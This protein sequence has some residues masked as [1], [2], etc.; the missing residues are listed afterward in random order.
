V[1]TFVRFVKRQIIS[2]INGDLSTISRKL[3]KL[4]PHLMYFPLYVLAI[5]VVIII[6]IIGPI[7]LI[8]WNGALASRIGTFAANLELYLCEKDSGINVPKQRYFDIFFPEYIPICNNQLLL[9]WKRVL[10]IWPR[11]IFYPI[12][13]VNKIIP[14]GDAHEFST[15]CNDR[16]FYNL[17]DQSLPHLFFTEDEEE[18][19]AQGLLNLGIPIENKFVCLMVRDSAYLPELNYHSYRDGDINKYILAA[20]ELTRRGYYVIRMGAAVNQKLESKNPKIID[21]ATNGYRSDF[22]DIYLGAKCT[23]CVSTSTGFDAVPTIFRRPNV[24]ITVP[25]GYIYTFSKNFLSITKHHISIKDGHE[26]S[27]DEIFDHNVAYALSTDIFTDNGVRL[28]ENSPEEIRDLVIE[29]DERI[30]GDFSGED[31]VR[32]NDSIRNYVKNLNKDQQNLHGEVVSLFGAKFIEDN[33]SFK[34]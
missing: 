29:M 7:F 4:Y 11:F 15:S 30:N 33:S 18:R 23:F 3:K 34:I 31:K 24:F 6:R 14:G 2:I 32:K 13:V 8:R 10:R 28:V 27:L 26:L 25:V 19:G 9:M 17:Y 22:M 1:K 12:K 16:D 5:P 20:E 21:Y